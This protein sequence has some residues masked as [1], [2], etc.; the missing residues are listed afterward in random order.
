MAPGSSGC[1]RDVWLL[2]ISSGSS[3][4]RVQ[5]EPFPNLAMLAFDDAQ[6]TTQAR[7]AAGSAS[8]RRCTASWKKEEDSPRGGPLERRLVPRRRGWCLKLVL[9]GPPSAAA[10]RIERDLVDHQVVDH[11][12]RVSDPSELSAEADLVV[13]VLEGQQEVDE[14]TRALRSGAR[15]LSATFAPELAQALGGVTGPGTVVLTGWSP[16]LTSLLAVAA[17]EE[18]KAPT[19]VRIA[20]T[21]SC[22]GP[23]GPMALRAAAEALSAS[24]VVFDG[25]RWR[26][27]R[28][29]SHP[30]SVHFPPPLGWMK[31]HLSASSE[32]GLL[33]SRIDSLQ[34]V[35]VQG[36]IAEPAASAIARIASRQNAGALAGALL[37]RFGTLGA[38]SRGQGGIGWSA[39]RADAFGASG[40]VATLGVL[41]R[42]INM[43]AATVTTTVELLK[44]EE[45]LPSGVC[46]PTDFC[47]SEVMLSAIR[48]KG[49]VTARLVR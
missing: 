20:W 35:R 11:V 38:G 31:T 5:S 48:S 41:D 40:E 4:R 27:E 15:H 10:V 12:E 36:G 21:N 45:N 39:V 37:K 1:D 18:V 34:W 46:L 44:A 43:V 14:A 47:S 33:P 8:G 23:E 7:A 16:G 6:H 26:R 42:W 17:A 24:A 9:L 3:S 22:Q 2:Q 30:E 25:A 28:S 32:S 13:S 19:G 49:V 29:G